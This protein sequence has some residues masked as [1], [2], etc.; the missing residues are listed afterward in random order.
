MWN[1]NKEKRHEFEREWRK[2]RGVRGTDKYVN[3][4]HIHDI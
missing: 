4:V 2:T 3:R 1:K